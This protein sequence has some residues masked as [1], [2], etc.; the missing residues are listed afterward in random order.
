RRAERPQIADI[1]E[2]CDCFPQNA[3][4]EL[5][6]A[7]NPKLDFVAEFLRCATQ[8]HQ[9]VGTAQRAE[10]PYHPSAPK[11]RR[12][13]RAYRLSTGQFVVHDCRNAAKSDNWRVIA[14]YV[15]DVGH[16]QKV[17]MR[18]RPSLDDAQHN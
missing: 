18:E 7:S 6:D 14:G 17:Y 12:R 16:N 2:G 1:F 9:R 8:Y 10:P 11:G 13:G 3:G 15:S 5:V 4:P